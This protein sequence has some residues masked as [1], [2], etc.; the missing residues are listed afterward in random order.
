MSEIILSDANFDEEL[1]KAPVLLV[2]LWAEWC[3]PCKM[4]GPSIAELAKEF[5]GKAVIGKLDV[6]NN[7]SI[8]TRFGVVSIPTLLFFKNGELK[9][10]LIGAHP[11]HTIAKKLTDIIGS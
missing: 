9:D 5:D 6:D 3:G 8:A 2:D 10:K 11:K 1:K 4:I 7:P